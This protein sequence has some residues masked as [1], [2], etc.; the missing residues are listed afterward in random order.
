MKHR[1]TDANVVP[2]NPKLLLAPVGFEY[3]YDGQIHSK[4]RG[5]ANDAWHSNIEISRCANT[6]LTPVV[7]TA[8]FTIVKTWCKTNQLLT[9]LP[10]EVPSAGKKVQN[11]E[12]HKRMLNGP[13]TSPI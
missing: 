1:I 10:G 7:N 3:E 9:S 11:L 2:H 13:S 8:P 5:S 4:K 12:S 6:S